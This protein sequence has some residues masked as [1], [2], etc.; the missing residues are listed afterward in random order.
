MFCFVVEIHNLFFTFSLVSGGVISLTRAQVRTHLLNHP[1]PGH[2][3]PVTLTN[4]DLSSWT[5][6][7]HLQN[8]YL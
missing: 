7:V 4:V 8:N 2:Y 1:T 3:Y 6:L 5:S